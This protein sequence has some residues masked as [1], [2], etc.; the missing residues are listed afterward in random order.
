MTTFNKTYLRPFTHKILNN[1]IKKQ[2]MT[3][4][5]TKKSSVK[6]IPILTLVK[7]LIESLI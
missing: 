3:T 7:A 2:Q 4:N 1:M 5:K 6:S